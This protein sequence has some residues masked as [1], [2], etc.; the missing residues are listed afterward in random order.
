MDITITRGGL[1]RRDESSLRIDEGVIEVKEIS[2]WEGDHKDDIL[3]YLND[4]LVE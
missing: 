1:F 3:L 4:K 2:Q